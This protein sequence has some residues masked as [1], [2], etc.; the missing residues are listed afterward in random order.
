M[1]VWTKL[2]SK[3]IT[4]KKMQVCTEHYSSLSVVGLTSRRSKAKVGFG[5]SDSDGMS[6][7]PAMIVCV[8]SPTRKMCYWCSAISALYWA[9]YSYRFACTEHCTSDF[10]PKNTN[11]WF[12]EIMRHKACSEPQGLS[13][14]STGIR[15]GMGQSDGST[16]ACRTQVQALSTTN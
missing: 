4:S 8:P 13:L 5:H 9:L 11:I 6:S 1:Y 15:V 3:K 16:R 14:T 2:V 7:I 10:W 12:Q